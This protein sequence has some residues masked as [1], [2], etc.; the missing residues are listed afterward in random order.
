MLGNR[1]TEHIHRALG[2]T[3]AGKKLQRRVKELSFRVPSG[4]SVHEDA[5]SV[6]G[7]AQQVADAA[8]IQHC[9]GHGVGL[10]YIS[11]STPSLGTSMCHRCSPKKE[12]KKKQLSFLYILLVTIHCVHL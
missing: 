1:D 7:L 8:Q 3:F 6:P 9:C 10:S 12:K 11:D 2:D 4:H 5:G